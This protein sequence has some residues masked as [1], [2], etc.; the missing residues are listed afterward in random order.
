MPLA[1]RTSARV[2]VDTTMTT[3][4]AMTATSQPHTNQATEA[5]K[6]AGNIAITAIARPSRVCGVV[7][8]VLTRRSYWIRAELCLASN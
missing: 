7:L 1:D 4:A 3:V 2:K 8:D 6:S 5:Q